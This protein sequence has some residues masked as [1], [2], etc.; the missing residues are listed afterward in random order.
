MLGRYVC[1]PPRRRARRG[2]T[3][4]LIHLGFHPT[5]ALCVAGLACCGAGVALGLRR[6]FSTP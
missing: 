6:R 2:G 1:A 3:W 4:G 5:A